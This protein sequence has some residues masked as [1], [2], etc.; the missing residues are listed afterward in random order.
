M[1]NKRNIIA[2]ILLLL[3]LLV[4]VGMS[5]WIILNESFLNPSY[6]PDPVIKKYF[7]GEESVV[8][9]GDEHAPVT[10][11]ENLIEFGDLE[12]SY[13][14]IL[15]TTNNYI[16]GKPKNAGVYD[17]KVSVKDLENS[18]T[19][20]KFTIKPK[21]ISISIDGEN[22][23]IYNRSNQTP[24]LKVTNGLIGEDKCNLSTNITS[25]NA[26]NYTLTK[27]NI[28]LGNSNYTL[29]DTASFDYIINP[30]SITSSDITITGV[31]GF[32]NLGTNLDKDGISIVDGDTQLTIDNDYVI[33]EENLTA[34]GTGYV[35]ITGN[36]NYTGVIK[37]EIEVKESTL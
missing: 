37:K 16:S 13:K 36:G 19:N 29:S 8:Y 5:T 28:I 32:I 26:G 21:E 12:F 17:V 6:N 22:S 11:V 3:P 31:P 20:V 14:P 35:I 25:V 10:S 15:D 30:K 23:F 7:S 34:L 1:K 27:D 4:A 2:F 9:D 33:T 24:L 18:S